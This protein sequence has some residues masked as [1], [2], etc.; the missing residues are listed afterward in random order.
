MCAVLAWWRES[1]PGL[2]GLG[3]KLLAE[4]QACASH[5]NATEVLVEIEACQ[6]EYAW[7]SCAITVAFYRGVFNPAQVRG[8]TRESA[9]G[10]PGN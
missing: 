2:L 10:R 1:F 4:Q 6:L 8:C 7:R 5:D 3:A 9:R